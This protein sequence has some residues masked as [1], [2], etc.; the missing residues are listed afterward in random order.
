MSLSHSFDIP[1]AVV[2]GVKKA[3]MLNNFGHW[4]KVNMTNPKKCIDGYVWTY[5]TIEAYHALWPY[6]SP[7]EIRTNLDQM[8]TRGLIKTGCYN[9][10]PRDR[11]KWYALT[12]SA[13]TLLG[14]IFSH[15][16]KRANASDQTGKCILPDGQMHLTNPANAFAQTGRPLP[17]IKPVQKPLENTH[18]PGEGVKVDIDLEASK[19]N[20]GTGGRAA[21]DP[22]TP[23][24]FGDPFTLASDVELLNV[25]FS[26]WFPTYQ[27]DANRVQSQRE[28]LHLT[29]EERV[30]AQLH[31]PLYV[32]SKP[33]K[34]YRGLPNNYLSEKKFM[35][36]IA[37]KHDTPVVN[38]DPTK[39]TRADLTGKDYSKSGKW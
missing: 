13:C 12:E 3:V 23:R 24:R 5:N 35:N 37:S 20:K 7:K 16:P 33:N 39:R 15:L 1:V 2:V 21:A 25:P 34:Q 14:I 32:V 22:G 8:E 6:M 31:T 27:Y 9:E 18:T 38:G 17:D 4:H 36:E 11:T 29:D 19:K 10:H 26:E 28:W 30:I